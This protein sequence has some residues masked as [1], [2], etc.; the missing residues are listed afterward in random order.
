M[1]PRQ[2]ALKVYHDPMVR[3]QRCSDPHM[4]YAGLVGQLVHIYRI[5]TAGL[6][7]RETG[8]Y[9]NIIRF[10]DV[11]PPNMSPQEIYLAWRDSAD[12]KTPFPIIR[13]EE[14]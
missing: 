10:E 5:T 13:P 12:P 3:I 14:C 8:G 2:W 6:W 9:T 7:A 1:T 11:E 4:W